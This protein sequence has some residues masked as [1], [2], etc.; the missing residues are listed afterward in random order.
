MTYT[1]GKHFIRGLLSTVIIKH[2]IMAVSTM[3]TA[4]SYKMDFSYS[5]SLSRYSPASIYAMFLV[6]GCVLYINKLQCIQSFHETGRTVAVRTGHT[7]SDWSPKLKVMG[8]TLDWTFITSS[9]GGLWGFH[10]TVTPTPPPEDLHL[11]TLSDETVLQKPC[12]PLVRK[13]LGG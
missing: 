11:E 7:L 10:F 13:L 5:L 3:S 2:C 9:A 4:S 8:D 12:L 6:C 1:V